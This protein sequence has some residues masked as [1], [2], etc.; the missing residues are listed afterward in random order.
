MNIIKRL[1]DVIFALVLIILTIFPIIII[2]ILIKIESK[3]PGIY[4]SKRIGKNNEI[5][6]MPKLRS[7]YC[8]APELATHNF[9]QK[10]YITKI[11]G[12]IRR[13]SLD[14]LPQFFLVL[15]GKMS[16]VGPRP[17]LHTQ[18]DLIFLRKKLNIDKL[19]PGITGLAQISGRDFLSI[20]EKVD[21]EKVYFN[22]RSFFYDLIIVLK[23]I[24]YLFKSNNISH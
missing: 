8:N 5:F 12:F 20:S 21:C 7:M 4:W 15:S 19:T 23:T 24:K 2:I 17:A 16:V 13:T 3:G 22:N 18:S 10:G 9:D 6:L 14:E 1:F 11:G